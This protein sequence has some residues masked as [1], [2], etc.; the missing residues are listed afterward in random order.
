MNGLKITLLGTGTS[1]GVP[2]L[3]CDCTTCISKDTRDKRLRCSVLIESKDTTIVIDTSSDFRQ[4]MLLYN[5]K[6]ID[7]VI[8]THHHFDHIGGF[9]DIRAYN[10]IQQ[11][12]MPIYLNKTTCDGLKRTFTYAFEIPDQ[13]GGGVPLIEINYIN[14][15]IIN[16]NGIEVMPIPYMH[17]NLEVLGFRI[18]NFAYCT[19]TNFIPNDSIK[20]LQGLDTLI[21]DALRYQKHPTHFTVDQALECALK[22]NAKQTYFTHIAH[23]IKHSELEA[24][25]PKNIYIAYD[26]IEFLI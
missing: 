22:I 24:K 20:K 9:D 5:V 21:L 6:K 14:R 2:L 19:D 7:A 16:I 18:G 1:S 23:Q 11:K 25:L 13:I 17:G 10:Y 26:G 12:P 4:Q 8:Y 3:A 15:D